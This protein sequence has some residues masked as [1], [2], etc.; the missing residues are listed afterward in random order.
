MCSCYILPTIRWFSLEK[1]SAHSVCIH[2]NCILRKRVL[3]TVEMGQN[4]SK[5]VKTCKNPCELQNSWSQFY[6][7]HYV[8]HVHHVHY[9]HYVQSQLHCIFILSDSHTNM[10]QEDCR[11]LTCPPPQA[12]CPQHSRNARG[13]DTVPCGMAQNRGTIWYHTKTALIKY[14]TLI[15]PSGNLR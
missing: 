2:L 13:P 3:S 12:G 5:H 15:I 4:N 1:E 8:H 9:V 6:Y 11:S 7:V 14:E 10:I